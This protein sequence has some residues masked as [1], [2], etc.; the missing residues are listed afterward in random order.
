MI[1]IKDISGDDFKLLKTRASDRT[2]YATKSH[3]AEVVK[4]ADKLRRDGG[5]GCGFAEDELYIYRKDTNDL[6]CAVSVVV[7][8]GKIQ[9]GCHTFN[10]KNSSILRKWLKS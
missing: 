2:F 6:L 7:R 3:I 1:T 4:A 10:R 5:S 9:L 8:D